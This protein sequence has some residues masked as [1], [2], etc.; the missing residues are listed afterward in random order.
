MKKQGTLKQILLLTDGCSNQGEDPQA[1]ALLARERGITV[2]VIGILD[3]RAR[4]DHG[5]EEVE[6][7]AQAGGGVSQIVYS[8]QLSQTVQMVTQ[9]AMTQTLQGVI[10]QEI[11]SILGKDKLIEDLPPEKRGEIVEVVDELSETSTLE[12]VV[13]VDVSA[14]MKTKLSTVKEA[15]LD[16]SVSLDSRSGMNAFSMHIFPGKR[17]DAD[18]ILPWTPDLSTIA[19]IF[20]KLTS[21]GITPTGP[22]L[23]QALEAFESKHQSKKRREAVSDFEFREKAE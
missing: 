4:D 19:N 13:L 1:I 18:E 15:L 3:E 22:A 7:I 12:V 6:A 5:L 16:L 9:Q 8:S 11:Q 20:P 23:Q 14:S 2:N 10:N 17:S 21:G